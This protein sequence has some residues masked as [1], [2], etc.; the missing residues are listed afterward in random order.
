MRSGILFGILLFLI[1]AAAPA[2]VRIEGWHLYPELRKCPERV[3]WNGTFDVSVSLPSVWTKEQV[4]EIKFEWTVSGGDIT[5]GQGTEKI[6]VRPGSYQQNITAEVDMKGPMF[7]NVSESCNV[8]VDDPPQ[9]V[10]HDEFRFSNQEYLEM[11]LHGFAADLENEPAGRGYIIIYPESNQRYSRIERM[12]RN[13]VRLR[14]F[15][16]ARITLVKSE[17]NLKT[18][19]QLWIVPPGAEDPPP[20]LQNRDAREKKPKE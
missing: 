7:P 15:D 19:I 3:P 17:K 14:R 18:M 9:A 13:W 4:S 5:D 8:S 11:R 20:G 2:Q 10:L 6:T 16:A 1:A 12:I